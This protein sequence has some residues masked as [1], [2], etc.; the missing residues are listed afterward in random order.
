MVEYPYKF[1]DKRKYI[2]LVIFVY[3]D[4]RYECYPIELKYKTA[5]K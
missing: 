4:N 5:G 2:D 1:E 3:E